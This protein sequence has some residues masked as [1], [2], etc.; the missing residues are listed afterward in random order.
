VTA[1]GL[2]PVR[3]S[4]TLPLVLLSVAA[5]GGFRVPADGSGFQFL[6]PPL[7]ALVLAVLLMGVM[8]RAGLLVPGLLVSDA[9]RG[10]ENASGI[11]VLAALFA[12]SAQVIQCLAPEGGLLH[13]LYYVFMTVLLWN[14]LAAAPDR[15]RLLHSLFVIFGS[16]F[17]LKYVALASLFDPEGGTLR[18]VLS[19]LLEGVALGTL[20]HEAY[21]PATGYAAFFTVLV[22]LAALTLLPRPVRPALPA[23][24]ALIADAEP[25]VLV[26]PA[27]RS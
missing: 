16:A 22:Y 18:R 14:T 10:L 9:R 20:Q 17:L 12:A 23:G 8:A 5:A 25:A 7:M 2:D 13:V 27:Q 19:A 6:P 24:Q 26:E 21:A 1:R 4:Y 3:E 11:V 15:P